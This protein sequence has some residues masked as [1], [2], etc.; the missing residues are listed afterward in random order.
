MQEKKLTLLNREGLIHLDLLRPTVRV[1]RKWSL[2]RFRHKADWSGT[3]FGQFNS[4]RKAKCHKKSSVRPHEHQ[5]A[6]GSSQSSA[7][8]RFGRCC[9]VEIQPRRLKKLLELLSAYWLYIDFVKCL[10]LYK[11]LYLVHTCTSSPSLFIGI[12]C[13]PEM[14]SLKKLDL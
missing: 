14:C 6:E 12:F 1:Q 4:C 5:W 8:L 9:V 10:I 7:W 2:M 3:L 13:H 11:C